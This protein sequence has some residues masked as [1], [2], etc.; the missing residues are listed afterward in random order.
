MA[1]LSYEDFKATTLKLLKGLNEDVQ[2]G[3]KVIY[4]K[5]KYK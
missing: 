3:K 2:K 4:L 5:C 1:D